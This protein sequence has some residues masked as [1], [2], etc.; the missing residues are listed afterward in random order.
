SFC[1]KT[2]FSVFMELINLSRCR[3]NSYIFPPY[4]FMVSNIPSPNKNPGLSIEIFASLRIT[5]ASH[6]KT[7]SSISEIVN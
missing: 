3:L 6:K 5:Q 1:F 2:Y 4:D 7:Y